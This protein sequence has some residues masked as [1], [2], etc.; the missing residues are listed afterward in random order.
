MQSAD[1]LVANKMFLTGLIIS[2][3]FQGIIIA[4]NVIHR[5]GD[6]NRQ[7]LEKHTPNPIRIRFFL[8]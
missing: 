7:T 5:Y 4:C 8:L 3:S 2:L 6:V 1:R